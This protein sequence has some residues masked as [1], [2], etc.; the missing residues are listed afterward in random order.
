MITLSKKFIFGLRGTKL[1]TGGKDTV[2]VGHQ[3]VI[4]FN[5]ASESS[6]IYVQ[7]TRNGVLDCE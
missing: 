4:G 6:V 1:I 7:S 3:Y 2:S 5:S